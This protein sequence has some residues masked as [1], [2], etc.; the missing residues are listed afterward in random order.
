MIHGA[1]N[2]EMGFRSI[3]KFGIMSIT[4]SVTDNESNELV[5]RLYE[6]C[7]PWNGSLPRISS[8]LVFVSYATHGGDRRII[9]T[10]IGKSVLR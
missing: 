6:F 1:R 5:L 3:G 7:L 8:I 10:S 9:R 4:V 2:L